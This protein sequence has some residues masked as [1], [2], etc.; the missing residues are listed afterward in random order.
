MHQL[1]ALI[2]CKW[3]TT[4]QSERPYIH[5]ATHH[6]E[7]KILTTVLIQY[8]YGTWDL[9]KKSVGIRSPLKKKIFSFPAT[10]LL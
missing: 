2:K 4:V 1:N 10:V 5:S 9:E 6:R 3:S 7:K 8:F